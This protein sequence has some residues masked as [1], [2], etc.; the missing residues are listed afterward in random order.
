MKP[1]R[2]YEALR[3]F[4]TSIEGANYFLTLCTRERRAGL[5][6]TTPAAAIRNELELIANDGTIVSRAWVIM[7]D[8]LHLFFALTGRLA[9][10][11]V[12]GRIK[13]KTRLALAASGLQWQGNYY[14]HRL[15]P[16]DA[17]EDVLRY[18]FLN[19][20]RAALLPPTKAYPLFWMSEK[21]AEWFHP[22]LED[23]RPF[24]EW[25]V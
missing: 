17:A 15:R 9:I 12:A 1:P 5:A 3:R 25:L 20:Y 16:G 4:R 10:G 22:T 8:H 18:L 6:A 23:G 14:E 7:P 13:A 19:P 2:G 21:D 11:Q 24:P